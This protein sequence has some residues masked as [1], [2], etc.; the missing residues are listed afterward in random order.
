M[1]DLL[2]PFPLFSFV[3]PSLSIHLQY[4]DMQRRMKYYRDVFGSSDN[5][6][7]EALLFQ[8]LN[9]GPE[10]S[11]VYS[12]EMAQGAAA[13]CPNGCGEERLRRAGIDE[14]LVLERDAIAAVHDANLNLQYAQAKAAVSVL[15]TGDPKMHLP[16]KGNQSEMQEHLENDRNF[17][18][19]FS[20]VDAATAAMN[21]STTSEAPGHKKSASLEEVSLPEALQ[22]EGQ[23]LAKYQK[24]NPTL[25]GNNR[26]APISRHV[27]APVSSMIPDESFL[28]T[29]I[30]KNHKR[31]ETG[32]PGVGGFS[33]TEE[34]VEMGLD[35][36][37]ATA[38]PTI[39]EGSRSRGSRSSIAGPPS[40]SSAAATSTSQQSRPTSVRVARDSD[41]PLLGDD[42]SALTKGSATGNSSTHGVT[43]TKKLYG[44]I[45]QGP[46]GLAT[47]S[48]KTMALSADGKFYLREAVSP[49]R[50]SPA[51]AMRSPA[52]TTGNLLDLPTSSGKNAT[53]T[54][55]W[56]PATQGMTN[57]GLSRRRLNTGA[58]MQSASSSRR[59][60]Y[61]GTKEPS[62]QWAAVER[63]ISDDTTIRDR[64][65]RHQGE[66]YAIGG[67]HKPTT[68]VWKMP[69]FS[70]LLRGVWD[71]IAG[72]FVAMCRYAKHKTNAAVDDLAR[73]STCAVVTFT[74]R[75]AAVAARN[76]IADGRGQT[77][78]L[79][80][81]EVP[82][83]PLADA[84]ACDFIT[85]RGCCRPVSLSIPKKQQ[86]LRKYFSLLLLAFIYIFYTFPISA[87]AAFAD[88][89]KLYELWPELEEIVNNNVLF[90]QILSGIVPA[91][92]FTLFF[93][94]CPVMFK[95]IANF[96]SNA[97]SVAVAEKAALR[98]YWWFMVCT[99]FTGSSLMTVVLNAINEGQVANS[100]T[101]VLIEIAGTIPTQV[102]S[103]W[104]NW[105]IVRTTMT[106]PL[107]Y[108]LQVNTFLF[109]FIGWKCCARCVVGGGPGGPIPY[110]IYIDSGVVFLCIVTLA[111]ASPLV[112][113]FA[114]LYFLYC[115][116][117]WRRNCLFVYR[118][119]FD[120]G[121]SRWPFLSE[122]FIWSMFVG[123]VLLTTMM[124]LKEAVGPAIF[125]ALP[126]IPTLFFRKMS[127]HRFLRSYMDAGL[128]Q[129][130]LLDGW[131]TS[132]PLDIEKREEFRQFLVDSHKAAYIPICIAGGA[133]TILTA[134]PA[135]TMPHE[136]DANVDL[137]PA[138]DVDINATSNSLDEGSL[139]WAA[140][141]PKIHARASNQ[142]GAQ[143]RRFGSKSSY[144]S[145]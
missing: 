73:E 45:A 81:E 103:T 98:Y 3:P 72:I 37:H 39:N 5:E 145:R 136:Y 24:R 43:D 96:G 70:S 120:S 117:L 142:K 76:C 140:S 6:D 141:D 33:A 60:T 144:E 105:I 4:L 57:S 26:P 58:S 31:A 122:I 126:I 2:I 53:T 11:A 109:R 35:D 28:R 32:F 137:P 47:K 94:L 8:A 100:V 21:S 68:G 116:P 107:Q 9:Y 130:S 29:P 97:T 83:P 99:A 139:G 23:L 127:R 131:D 102:S 90:K 46:S 36:L 63:I 7:V 67:K 14:L 66:R 104:I 78:W 65:S 75:Q 89:S 13:C 25:L 59:R 135:L 20:H 52:P 128:L 118:P 74:S 1:F 41:H 19:T 80:V 69:T 10:Q 18:R 106:L 54:G 92:L 123:Q 12:R 133:S 38:L 44:H 143:L 114:L 42:P 17:S 91:L 40:K 108:M 61:S 95:T 82:V 56:P 22:M 62:V 71:A 124:A 64:E 121:G 77:R 30:T 49:P 113:P 55:E 51:G 79:T 119:K 48:N 88:P 110:R 101:E 134:E 27:S 86:M 15:D 111:P 132:V 16:Q 138:R 84:A 115:S 50:G 125:A 87:A 112:A 93:A 34:G 85:C 129:T